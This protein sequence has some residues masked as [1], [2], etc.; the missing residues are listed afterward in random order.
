MIPVLSALRTLDGLRPPSFATSPLSALPLPN[1]DEIVLAL[2]RELDTNAFPIL[3]ARESLGRDYTDFSTLT[4]LAARLVGAARAD[5]FTIAQQLFS[6]CARELPALASGNPVIIAGA[7]GRL[8]AHAAA[9]VAHGQ[10]RAAR[11]ET[12]LAPVTSS[13]EKLAATDDA[14]PALPGP[15]VAAGTAAPDAEAAGGAAPAAAHIP[16]ATRAHDPTHPPAEEDSPELGGTAVMEGTQTSDSGSAQGRQ[17]VAAARSA[18]GTPYAWGGTGNGGFDCSGLTQWA[19][20]QAGVE[21][22]RLAQ[23]Q[24]VG[25]QVSAAELQ[26]G[27]L[28]VWDGHVAMYAGDGQLIEAGDPVQT[29]PLRTSNMGMAF[30]GF[31]RPTG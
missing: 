9:A 1:I 19:W 13:L 7:V 30:K 29:N 22:P 20:R 23:D 10:E 16:T 12:E 11:L 5:I 28:A 26:P 3:H 17:A 6:Q 24:C 14:L 18:I 31:Y 15:P 4:G 27:D 8:G 21:L 2:A 25:R